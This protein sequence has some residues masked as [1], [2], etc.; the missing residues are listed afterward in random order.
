LFEIVTGAKPGE[1]K[2]ETRRKVIRADMATLRA[3]AALLGL[4]LPETTQVERN[5]MRL[6]FCEAI[7]GL[8]EFD[9]LAGA[10]QRVPAAASS[11]S[12]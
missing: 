9:E 2:P 7:R 3:G 10:V 11:P 5:M 6:A 8:D 4:V 12:A 1:L